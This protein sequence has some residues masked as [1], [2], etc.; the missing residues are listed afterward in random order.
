MK[1]QIIHLSVHQTSKVIA[2]MHA[3]MI[4]VLFIL[5]TALGYW[6]QGHV[7]WGVLILIFL[8]LFIWLMMYI[9]YVIACWFYNLVIPWTGGIEL[10][11]IDMP[12][13][14]TLAVSSCEEKKEVSQ[15]KDPYSP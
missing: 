13:P 5:P 8:P 11:V 14:S 4:A 7:V 10:D 6:F 1:K 9:G 15:E 2:A 12:E 3:A